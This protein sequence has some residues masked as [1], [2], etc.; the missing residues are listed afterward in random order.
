M[1]KDLFRVTRVCW[2]DFIE[3]CNTTRSDD[4]MTSFQVIRVSMSHFARFE[5]ATCVPGRQISKLIE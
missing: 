3:R 1:V 2:R 4:H 5:K